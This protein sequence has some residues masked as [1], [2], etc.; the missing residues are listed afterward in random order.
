MRVTKCEIIL[1]FVNNTVFAVETM[2]SEANV[3]LMQQM[4]YA[5]VQHGTGLLVHWQV[6]SRHTTFGA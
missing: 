3:N 1:P 2:L 6:R 5:V 4:A